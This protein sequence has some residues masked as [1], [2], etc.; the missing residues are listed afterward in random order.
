LKREGKHPFSGRKGRKKRGKRRLA[1]AILSRRGEKK[2]GGHPFSTLR[3]GGERRGGRKRASPCCF[4]SF[5]N[6]GGKKKK[7]CRLFNISHERGVGEKGKKGRKRGDYLL[8]S[9][10]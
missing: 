6:L 4:P 3:R 7:E 10:L 5:I 2:G 1:C 9:I 8:A